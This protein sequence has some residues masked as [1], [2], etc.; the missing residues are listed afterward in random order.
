LH[1]ELIVLFVAAVA[2]IAHGLLA[3]SFYRRS[4]GGPDPHPDRVRFMFI[5][6]G[7]AMLALWLS[8]VLAL[9]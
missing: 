9:R 1:I 5:G 2:S 3:K 7:T 4:L 8:E 6:I